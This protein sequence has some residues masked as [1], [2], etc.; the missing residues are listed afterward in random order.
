[1]NAAALITVATAL[2]MV[3]ACAGWGRLVARWARA[4]VDGGLTLS[5]GLAV[6]LALG[7]GATALGIATAPVLVGIE[8]V[9]AAALLLPPRARWPRFDR[10]QAIFMGVAGVVLAVR[11]LAISNVIGF[12]PC[13]DLLA[14][15][16]LVAQLLQAGDLEAPFSL[17]R[18]AAYGGQTVLQAF[19]AP[20]GDPAALGV[21]DVGLAPIF[22]LGLGW[23]FLRRYG[24]P[25]PLPLAFCL[26]VGL[27]LILRV[28]TASQATTLV[29]FLALVRT[30]Y[31]VVE[32]EQRARLCV[33][34]GMVAA[35]ACSLR[36]FNLP[37]SALVMLALLPMH[38]ARRGW[39][40]ALA[41]GMLASAS[42][43]AFLAPWMVAL[44]ASSGTPL[45]PL[46]KGYHTGTVNYA[47]LTGGWQQ[48]AWSLP[49]TLAVPQL[50]SILAVVPGAFLLAKDR[51]VRGVQLAA[52]AGAVAI[53]IGF[54][55]AEPYA[56]ARYLQSVLATP[57][58]IVV[59]T[60]LASGAF[61]SRL[62]RGLL[63][64]VVTLGV[65]KATVVGAAS[66]LRTTPRD[67]FSEALYAERRAA[68]A[69]AQRLVP[70]AAPIFVYVSTPDGFDASRNR[71][72]NADEPGPVSPPPGL[73]FFKGS[74]AVASYLQAQGVR[75]VAFEDFDTAVVWCM[76]TKGIDR[77]LEPLWQPWKPYLVDLMSNLRELGHTR[78]VLYAAHGVVV[79]DLGG[80]AD[81]LSRHIP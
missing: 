76:N 67:D 62:L 37:F 81:P 11:L 44:Y 78:R 17:R 1:M 72:L 29:C 6:L 30:L 53:F 27:G 38:V 7:G 43:L 69:E 63:V 79:M 26:F 35:A 31:L 73:P 32:A 80:P 50:A 8:A 46:F 21:A 4:E 24:N 42:W 20:R 47:A 56:M 25:R 15:Q 28:N 14:Y 61:S 77:L 52:L 41:D 18:L 9:G 75:Y 16:P 12:E 64:A 10:D 5:W 22:L 13:D 45:Y 70:A 48:V 49:I 71:I 65:A 2:F 19:A 55:S 23:S 57:F 34:V 74:E 59:C 40:A 36:H 66:L 51:A 58:F 60:A 54:P 39:A 3:V 33:V 68:Y